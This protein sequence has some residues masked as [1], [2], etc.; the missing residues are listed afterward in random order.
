M[1][2]NTKYGQQTSVVCRTPDDLGQ[3]AKHLISSYPDFRVF[4]FYG[5]MGAGKTTFIKAICDY[6]GVTDVVTSPTFSIVNIYETLNK[7]PLNHFDFYRIKSQDEIFDIGY[8][9]YLFSGHYC[10]LEWPEKVENLLPRDI[11]KVTLEVDEQN[12]SRIVKF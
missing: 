2:G 7:G 5:E 4:A 1:Y 12:N 11:I 8:E 9:D 6:L 10:F 3:I